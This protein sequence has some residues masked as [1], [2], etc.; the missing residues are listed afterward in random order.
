MPLPQSAI[1][2]VSSPSTAGASRCDDASKP[3][4]WW[5]W[6]VGWEPFRCSRPRKKVPAIGL[7]FG[8]MDCTLYALDLASGK[9]QWQYRAE[10]G[11][12]A[13]P[14]VRAGAV[15]VGDLAGQFH[16]V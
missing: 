14:A 5:P 9:K 1:G 13:A 4:S 12:K 16:C 3:A 11:I 15:Y 7:S 2:N 10:G 8:A 6:P